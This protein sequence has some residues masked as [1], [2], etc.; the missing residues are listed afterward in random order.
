MPLFV[1]INNNNSMVRYIYKLISI[2]SL[3]LISWNAK[4][5][6]SLNCIDQ[7]QISVDQTCT[8]LI[9]ADMVLQNIDPACTYTVLVEELNGVPIPNPVPDYYIDQT[10]RVNVVSGTNSCSSIARIEDK[11][12][13][14]L[15][16]PPDT[17]VSCYQELEAEFLSAPVENCGNTYELVIDFDEVIDSVCGDV[18]SAMRVLTFHAEDQKGNPSTVCTQNILYRRPDLATLTFPRDYDD[19]LPTTPS[20]KCDE[21]NVWDLNDN[22][23]PDP[24]ETG[25]PMIE[26]I[27]IIP[28]ENLFCEINVNYQDDTISLCGNTFKVIRTWT[29]LD[30]CQPTDPGINPVVDIQIIKVEDDRRPEVICPDPFEGY[31][32]KDKCAASI[33]PPHPNVVYDCNATRYDVG[34]SYSNAG[35]LPTLPIYTDNITFV[36]EDSFYIIHDLP[37]GRNWI[38]YNVYDACNNVTVCSTYVDIIDD[39]VPTAVCD[40]HTV[41]TLGSDGTAK[42]FAHTFDDGSTD[43]CE[44]VEYEVRRVEPNGCT[45]NLFG[46]SV[47][48]CCTDAGQYVQ[49]QLRVTDDSGNRNSCKAEI[50]VDDKLKPELICEDIVIDCTVDYTDPVYTGGAPEVIDNCDITLSFSDGEFIKN[51]CGTGTF[52]RY[53]TAQ[54]NQYLKDYCSQLITV[55]VFDP[56]DGYIE[57]PEDLTINSC[58][59]EEIDPAISGYPSYETDAC[60]FIAAHYEDNTYNYHGQHCYEIWRKWKVIDWCQFDRD[61]PFSGGSWWYT[62]KIYVNDPEKPEINSPCEDITVNSFASDCQEPVFLQLDAMDNCT[63]SAYLRYDYRI[64]TDLNGTFEIYG[65]GNENIEYL[66]MGIN[67]IKWTVSDACGN[68]D[69]CEYLIRVVDAKSPTPYCLGGINTV[70]MPTTGTI[71]MWASD[72]NLNSFDNCDDSLRFSFSSDPNDWSKLYTCD[73]VGMDTVEIWVTDLSG[74][75]DFCRTIIDIQSNTNICDTSNVNNLLSV[76]GNLVSID[77]APIQE[78]KISLQ[79]GNNEMDVMS[80]SQGEYAFSNLTMNMDYMLSAFKNDDVKNGVSTL[81]LV[82]IQRHI[83]GIEKFVNPYLLIAADINNSNTITASDLISLRKIILNLSESFP[84]NTSW[85]F[86]SALNEFADPSEPWSFNEDV[87]ISQMSANKNENLMGVK[88]GDV[89]G[90]VVLHGNKD[91]YIRNS[92]HMIADIS[93]SEISL[94]MNENTEIAGFQFA[95]DLGVDDVVVERIYSDYMDID[96]SNY[97]IDNGQ[98]LVSIALESN[99]EILEQE[100]IL[101]I[102]YSA[103]DMLGT[104]SDVV[105]SDVLDSELYGTGY[106]VFD[107]DIETRSEAS[108]QEKSF[109]IIQNHPNPFSNGT[110]IGF[111]IPEEGNVKVKI[112]TIDGSVLLEK[113][114]KFEKGRHTMGLTDDVFP[115][116]GVYLYNIEYGGE[117]KIK[118]MI[119]L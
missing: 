113:E 98:L 72:L 43:N 22:F 115:G 65:L 37:V 30:W 32:D 70:I 10:V 86:M 104:E 53:W 114:Q 78:A 6:C 87:Y 106:E 79:S 68:F 56:F 67:R 48:F 2:I 24:E 3:V 102:L 39:D 5:Q 8:A 41:I 82:L 17:I 89:N 93:A 28:T 108:D 16:C 25:A 63:D 36:E 60:S 44:I 88:I 31:S 103:S 116:N 97:H 119:K 23:Y 18:Y 47:S 13:P 101:K 81:D 7:V 77:G 54:D 94:S 14:L 107:L 52:T 110:N 40:E 84:N 49:V 27:P 80:G 59:L 33:I 118:K 21:A 90:S 26:G 62:Q 57:W 11:L 117:R 99:L 35:G 46:P 45:D 34:Y 55:T 85:R 58:S 1:T 66:P 42:A 50:R 91:A 61:D 105:L 12:G 20:L 9:T 19:I 4:A 15:T 74:N 29:V 51:D 100:P 95:L 111:Y 69:K 64:D 76:H 112:Y 83:L 75:Q 109:D 92:K 96:E 38:Y 73:E 71:A